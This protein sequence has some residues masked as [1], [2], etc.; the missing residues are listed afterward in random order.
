M[1]DSKEREKEQWPGTPRK[2]SRRMNLTFLHPPRMWKLARRLRSHADEAHQLTKLA[3]NQKWPPSPLSTR[4]SPPTRRFFSFPWKFSSLIWEEQKGREFRLGALRWEEI[5][6]EKRRGALGPL[7]QELTAMMKPTS[8]TNHRIATL[9]GY[10]GFG[11]VLTRLM[12]PSLDEDCVFSKASQM[13][14]Y[15]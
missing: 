4:C 5:G 15:H 11:L 3:A 8:P 9:V 10:E 2:L 1:T 13:L 6:K 7:I 14:P 12:E